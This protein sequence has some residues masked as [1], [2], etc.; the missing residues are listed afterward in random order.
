[1]NAFTTMMMTVTLTM[2]AVMIPRIYLS[3]VVAQELCSDGEIEPLLQLLA[4]QNSWVRRQFG[5][6]AVAFALIWMVK[7]SQ[8]DLEIP[9]SMEAALAI[10]SGLSM[11]FAVLESLIAQRISDCIGGVPATAAPVRI[12]EDE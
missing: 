8:H 6:G 2:A 4:E 7:T 3:W 11:V 12:R 9:A 10:Y 5:C 1:M